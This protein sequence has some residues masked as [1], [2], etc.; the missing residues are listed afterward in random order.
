M[1]T[2][3]ISAISFDGPDDDDETVAANDGKIFTSASDSEISSLYDKYKRGRLILQ[4]DFQRQYVWDATKASRLIESALM[5]IPL[6]VIY[7]SQ[8]Q[9]GKE[10]VIDGQQRLT[11][12]FA[13]IDGKL[14]SN[15]AFKL[16]GLT[17][18][19]ELMGKTFPELAEALQDEIRYYTIRVVTF[20]K[21]SSE[22]LKFEMFERLNTGSVQL[23]AQELRNCIYRGSL[24]RAL[25]EMAANADFQVICGLDGPD[26][27]MHD[28]ELVLR[29]A[30]FFHKTYLNYKSPMRNF[31]NEE[32]YDQ[33]NISDKGLHELQDAFK[34]ACQVIRS[35]FGEHAFKRFYLG[36]QGQ[37]DGTWEPKKINKSLYDILMYSMAR[38]NKNMLYRHLD[39]IRE[40]LINLM[41]SDS[42]FIDAIERS[43]SSVQAV[44]T[45]FDKWRA[46][47]QAI[48]AEDI[49]QPRCFSYKLK[50]ELMQAD[51]TCA[52]CGQRIQTIDDAA[53]DH[54]EQYW[55]GGRTIPEN[56]RLTHRYCNWSRPRSDVAGA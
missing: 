32:A 3:D 36:K 1:N 5:G 31:L 10:Y 7:L 27:R 42:A 26:K 22:T 33:R 16:T 4:P 30:S 40:A 54:I 37:P 13:F 14:P 17:V 56:A 9:D 53:I 8:D 49:N 23:N 15:R 45:R 46:A 47:L 48:L 35:A 19:T 41:T 18:R 43:T 21:D 28:C 20:L 24:N 29:F 55:T 44:R 2:D 39:A 38:E 12:F 11:S 51:P 50:E 34:N 6:P 25:K 52:I